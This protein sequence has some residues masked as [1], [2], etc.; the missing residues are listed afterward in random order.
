MTFERYLY[1]ILLVIAFVL[2]CINSKKD[3]TLLVIC[4][5]LFFSIITESISDYF[6]YFAEM[7]RYTPYHFYIPIEYSLV[8]LYFS[9]L[10]QTSWLKKL[11]IVSMPFFI[12]FSIVISIY[13]QGINEFPSWQ[14]NIE[15]TLIIIW[16]VISLFN[17]PLNPDVNIF[18]TFQFWFCIA[19]M[20][21]FS[22]QFF[23]N[24]LFNS[25]KDTNPGITNKL[26]FIVYYILNY[27]FYT[28]IIF[29]L[30]CSRR[31]RKYISR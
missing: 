9:R 6:R 29:G 27:L 19:F 15:G 2:L 20:L 28:L 7:K 23:M 1:Y 11:L 13:L 26:I 31:T 18:K 16:C 5:L 24:G 4:W 22:G 10:V 25:L 21:L 30:L 3:K 8:T 12:L 17:L 14:Y